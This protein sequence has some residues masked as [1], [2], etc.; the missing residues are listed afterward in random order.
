MRNLVRRIRG[1][2]SPT[3]RRHDLLDRD[4]RHAAV[5]FAYRFLLARPVDDEGRSNYLQRMHDEG[6]TLREVAAE[7]AASDEFQSRLRATIARDRDAAPGALPHSEP[8]AEAPPL[9][10]PM[11]LGA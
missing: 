1:L 3:L 11:S 10:A 5:D 7:I 4:E 6:M 8:F 9:T 2:L